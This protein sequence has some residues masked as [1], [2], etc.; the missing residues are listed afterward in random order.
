MSTQAPPQII[1]SGT[2]HDGYKGMAPVG[3]VSIHPGERRK[4]FIDAY[5]HD[6]RK[7]RALELASFGITKRKFES[8]AEK[9]PLMRSAESAV[10]KFAGSP[11]HYE[12]PEGGSRR[13]Y[14]LKNT[15]WSSYQV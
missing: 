8:E 5:I 10:K 15:P 13:K 2:V 9:G 14:R 1:L 6:G 4:P 3:D 12:C 11:V 7:W